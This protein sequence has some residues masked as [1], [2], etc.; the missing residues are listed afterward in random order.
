MYS[1]S[2]SS[3]SDGKTNREISLSPKEK[4]LLDS[5]SAGKQKIEYGIVNKLF[6]KNVNDVINKSFLNKKY[7]CCVLSYKNYSHNFAGREANIHEINLTM[8]HNTNKITFSFSDNTDSTNHLEYY[9]ATDI[10]VNTTNIYHYCKA[11]GSYFEACVDEDTDNSDLDQK[12]CSDD[13]LVTLTTFFEKI[14]KIF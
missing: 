8:S 11:S 2:S 14:T 6:Q 7:T 10:F 3:I 4:Q 1:P 5:F 9:T 13:E 12:I